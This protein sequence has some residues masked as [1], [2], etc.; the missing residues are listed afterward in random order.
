MYLF[1]ENIMRKLCG[2]Y[3][4]YNGYET[5]KHPGDAAVAMGTRDDAL[6]RQFPYV[7]RPVEK[8]NIKSHIV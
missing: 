3:K 4:V 8:Q 7:Y 1:V 6:Q 2:N 5:A